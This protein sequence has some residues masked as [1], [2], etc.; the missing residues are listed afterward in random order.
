MQESSNFVIDGFQIAEAGDYRLDGADAT[1]SAE[2]RLQVSSAT[3]TCGVFACTDSE[4]FSAGPL[5][6]TGAL[7]EWT[8]GAGIDFDDTVGWGS[9]TAVLAQLQNDLSASTLANGE[10]AFIQKKNTGVGL[11]VVPEIPLPAA[12]WLFGSALLGLGLVKRRKA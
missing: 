2:G 1:V 3:T 10:L 9:D 11:V 7:T 4:I 12:A 8:A 6:V 5:S